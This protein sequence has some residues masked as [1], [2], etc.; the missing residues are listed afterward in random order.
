MKRLAYVIVTAA[1]IV[2]FQFCAPIRKKSLP[3]AVP[4]SS[5]YF[6]VIEYQRP[7]NVS[8]D[9]SSFLDLPQ[10]YINGKDTIKYKHDTIRLNGKLYYLVEGDIRLTP[11]EYFEYR[12]PHVSLY[13]QPDHRKLFGRKDHDT[14]IRWRAGTVLSYAVVRSSFSSQAHYDMVVKNM[15]LATAE[16]TKLTNIKFIHV[17]QKDNQDKKIPTDG[18]SFV[19]VG[20]KTYGAF[21]ANAFFP[22]QKSPEERVVFID[23]TYF[24]NKYDKLGMC[25]HE[26]GHIL[27]FLHEQIR[28]GMPLLCGREIIQGRYD[29]TNYDPTSV[30]HYPCGNAGSK[31]FT[32]SDS[33]KV[34]AA[35]AYSLIPAPRR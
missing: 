29:L 28:S 34:G 12:F 4:V 5:D 2:I 31:N 17:T 20:I 22:N 8:S 32:I 21:F 7:D 9:T 3:P 19:V 27:G 24:T 35:I 15:A 25:R 18:L 1:V 11:A 6:S 16:W 10:Y 23:S 30:M 33:D 13:P 26:V 14:L